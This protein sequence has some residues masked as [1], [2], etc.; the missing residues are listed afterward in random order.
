[1]W[2]QQDGATA[3]TARTSMNLLREHFPKRLISLRG[4]LQWSAHSPDLDPCDF[5]FGATLNL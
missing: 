5:F 3:H 1:V 4:D 2:F